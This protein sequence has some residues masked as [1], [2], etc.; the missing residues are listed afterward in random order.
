MFATIKSDTESKMEKVMEVFKKDLSGL[1]TGRASSGFLNSV[2]VEVYGDR[3]PISNLATVTVQ[4]GNM[5][6]VQVWDRS[7]VKSIEKAINLAELGVNAIS[8]GQSIRIPIPPLS[9]ERRKELAKL[10]GKSAEQAKVAVRNIRRNSME[11]IKD[12]ENISK[13]DMHR[14]NDE[15]QKITDLNIAKIDSLLLEKEKDIMKV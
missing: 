1:R 7:V 13:D 4:D 11:S 3:Q 10:A 6:M 5:L 12:I 8:E 15:V 9:E 2:Q 14:F